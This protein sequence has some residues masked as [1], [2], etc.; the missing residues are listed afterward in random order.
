MSVALAIAGGSPFRPMPAVSR[1]R[2]RAVA[3]TSACPLQQGDCA[4]IKVG[5]V[6]FSGIPAGTDAIHETPD[7][8]S[9]VYPTADDHLT[10]SPSSHCNH[11]ED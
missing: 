6:S 8:V 9:P 11:P 1:R 2:R 5:C 3:S 4:S 10:G 7:G